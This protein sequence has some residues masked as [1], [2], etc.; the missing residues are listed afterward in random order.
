MSVTGSKSIAA[1]GVLAASL[2]INVFFLVGYFFLGQSIDERQTGS[3]PQSDNPGLQSEVRSVL[4][5]FQDGY[6]KRD[7]DD[8]D[9]FME[10]FEDDRGN[11]SHRDEFS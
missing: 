8:L 1:R 9:A 11:R 10:L 5:S 2:T 3:L 6:V 4:Q 7:V